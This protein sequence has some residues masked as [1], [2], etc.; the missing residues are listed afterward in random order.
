MDLFQVDGDFIEAEG[1]E[2]A[3]QENAIRIVVPPQP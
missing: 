2:I 3:V 1:D